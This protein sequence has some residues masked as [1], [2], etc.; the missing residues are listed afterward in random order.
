MG[1]TDSYLAVAPDDMPRNAMRRTDRLFDLI[2]I[3]RD[4]RLHRASE[5]AE[6]LGVSVR[7][8]WRDMT[9]LAASGM[10][11]E[12]ERGVGYILRAPFTLPPMILS[13]VELEALRAGLRAV[14]AGE[15]AALAR[16]ARTLATKIASVTPAPAGEDDLFAFPGPEAE[17]AAAHLP[18]IRAA[19]RAKERLTITYIET[20]GRDT[21]RDIRPLALET[22]GKVRSLAAFCEGLAAF[23]SF[24]LDRI[25]AVAPTGEAFPDEP[26]RMLADW[27]A[28]GA[29][30]PGSA[31]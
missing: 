18:V 6:K 17:A 23:R 25:V 22:A 8:I 27:Q 24:R 20:D 14:A 31:G 3:L 29:P 4:G 12:G 9:T 28:G 26:G 10:P 19:I 21:H 30:P 13:T 11:L 1:E 2:Q 7:T 5:L 16:A 15:D